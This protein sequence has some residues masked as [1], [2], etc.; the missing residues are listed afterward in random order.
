MFGSSKISI[1]GIPKLDATIKSLSREMQT[2]I[3]EKAHRYS[4]EPLI[5]A[6]RVRIKFNTGNLNRSIGYE[7]PKFSTDGVGT[8]AVGARRG[9]GFKGYH[10]HL[11]EF[12]HRTRPSKK[13]NIALGLI[14][15]RTYN[16]GVGF[17]K[18]YP[19][20]APALQITRPII[21]AR[22]K[23]SVADQIE[24]FLRKK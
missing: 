8:I 2:K 19:F 16:K 9:K 15:V 18:P 24:K 10:G 21:L 12:G 3:M 13:T 1:S 6:A 20:M 23:T 22:I 17:V 4:A 11:L 5:E 7:K 14:Q